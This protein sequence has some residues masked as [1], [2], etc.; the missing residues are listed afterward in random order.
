ME[1]N[2]DKGDNDG[3]NKVAEVW[4][5]LSVEGL[6]ETVELVWLGEQEV[7]ESNNATFEFSTLVSSNGDW[8]ERFPED[9][10]TDVG[11]NE[12]RDTRAETVTLLQEFIKHKDHESSEEK[13]GNNEDGVDQTEFRDWSIHSRKKIS[14]GLSE[15]DQESEQLGGRLIEFSILFALHVDVNDFGTDEKLQ[16]HTGSNNWRHTKLH[17]STLVGGKDNSEPIEWI[18]SLL[19]DNTVKWDLAADQIDEQGPCGPTHLIV[20]RLL[21]KWSLNFWQVVDNWSN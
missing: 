21:F 16:D 8:G 5:I 1:V 13:L 4:S 19:L 10:F 7:E 11:G 14:K 9:Q 6:L 2:D 12:K 3:G 15:G 17:D 20:E 18:G